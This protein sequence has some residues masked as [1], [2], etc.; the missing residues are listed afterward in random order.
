M[1]SGSGFLRPE[2]F[3]HYSFILGLLLSWRCLKGDVVVASHLAGGCCRCPGGPAGPVMTSQ[4]AVNRAFQHTLCLLDIF[5]RK[6]QDTSS[7]QNAGVTC[8]LSRSHLTCLS[9]SFFSSLQSVRS[10]T[11]APWPPTAPAPSVR[12]T[13]TPSGRDPPP[14]CATRDTFA[15]RRT[16]PP[17]PAPV[18]ASGN[19]VGTAA[20][21]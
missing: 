4:R 2:V 20:Q 11:T 1:K 13:A 14:A 19:T 18:S 16:R 10:A 3:P 9:L 15:P 5:L 12:C 6:F 8:F 21:P 7:C 17:C